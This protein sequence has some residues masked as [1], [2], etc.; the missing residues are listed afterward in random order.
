MK[1]KRKAFSVAEAFIV[2]LIGSIALGMSAPMITKQ[3]KAQNMTDTQFQVINR[4]A[5]ELSGLMNDLMERINELE[6]ANNSIPQGSIVFFDS[7]T[8]NTDANNNGCP[9]GFTNISS[10]KAGKYIMLDSNANAG[11]I[12]KAEF[13]NHRHILGY[14]WSSGNDP[15]II[16]A[17]NSFSTS[18]KK[19][20]DD[21]FHFV[22]VNESR[23]FRNTNGQSA[24]GKT[25]S[26][27]FITSQDILDEKMK[28][29]NE[30]EVKPASLSLIACRKN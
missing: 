26:H 1:N 6:N 15:H 30:F 2:L 20:S 5:D 3:I 12:N 13:P 29:T 11:V 23:W 22:A 14:M 18:G 10:G 21:I 9:A 8:I 27:M 16:Y 7:S 19:N 4:Q 28:I 24:D 17:N 25:F